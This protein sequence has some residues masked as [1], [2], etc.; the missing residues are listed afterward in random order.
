[1]TTAGALFDSI[2]IFSSYKQ[3]VTG[4]RLV[5]GDIVRC[6]RWSQNLGTVAMTVLGFKCGRRSEKWHVEE[7]HVGWMAKGEVC[8]KLY[9]TG[10]CDSRASCDPAFR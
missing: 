6:G 9:K 8:S 7:L 5:L 3:V 2:S 4:K 1:M 10:R